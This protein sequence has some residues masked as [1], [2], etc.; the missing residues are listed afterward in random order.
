MAGIKRAKIYSRERVNLGDV[1]PLEIPFS[2]QIDIC[3][4]CNMQCRFCFHSDLNAIKKHNV[5]FG[6]MKMEDYIAVIDNIKNSI[7]GKI[8][9]LKLFKIGE[10][11]LNPH[12]VEMIKYAKEADIA[13]IIEITTNGILLDE[14]L[15]KGMIAAGLDILNIS[16]NGLSTEEYKDNCNLKIDYDKFIDNIQY[17]Y[18][19]RR[20]CKV[21]IKYSDTG[22][23]ELEKDK[24][25]KI[26]ENV[27]DEIFVE[28]IISTL[29]QDT[30]ISNHI[31]NRNKGIYGQ[32]LDKKK[33]CPFLF[34]T[35][36]IN[37]EGI[38]HLCCV[39]WKSEYIL[40]DMKNTRLS[41]IW[42]GDKI[43]ELQKAHLLGNKD[44]IK[45]CRNCESL[46]GSTIDNIDDCVDKILLKF[47][48]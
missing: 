42:N 2:V 27:C 41:D 43:R 28:N 18:N 25:Y 46:N 8:K 10:P 14:K 15:S 48:K 32:V 38:S 34:T 24:F 21:F 31:E 40:G 9:K 35:M 7:K 11:L 26:F 45:I 5:H 13:E 22:L 33:V 1:L 20:Q 36:V 3:S 6:Y 30:E 12:V 37:H 47:Q 23:N 19:N 16:V 44:K 29:W 39:D 17:F 4:V